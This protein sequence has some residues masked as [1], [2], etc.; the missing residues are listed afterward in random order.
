MNVSFLVMGVLHLWCVSNHM[1]RSTGRNKDNR[2]H[3]NPTVVYYPLVADE[4]KTLQL[5][6][7]MS[8]IISWQLQKVYNEYKIIN[9]NIT[10]SS[11]VLIIKTSV[12][13]Y[14]AGTIIWSSVN[15]GLTFEST[16]FFFFFN[17]VIQ[18]VERLGVTTALFPKM[19]TYS[20]TLHRYSWFVFYELLLLSGNAVGIKKNPIH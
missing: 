10:K 13:H 5:P 20:L 3:L 1:S 8:W 18:E 14:H 4:V 2:T 6:V 16:F 12:V 19:L 7:I 11:D 9:N 17:K 15:S